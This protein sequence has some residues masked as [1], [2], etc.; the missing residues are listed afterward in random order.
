LFIKGRFLGISDMKKRIIS[1]ASIST[2]YVGERRGEL[3][4]KR[5]F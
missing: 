5:S 2:L 4:K 1:K 3:G